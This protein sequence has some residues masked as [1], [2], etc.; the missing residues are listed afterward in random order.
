MSLIDIK[1]INIIM[2]QISN[3][4]HYCNSILQR[5]ILSY[6]DIFISFIV[7]WTRT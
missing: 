5:E 1:K 2:L 7:S 6:E 3:I 4:L